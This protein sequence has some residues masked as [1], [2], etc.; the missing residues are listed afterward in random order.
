MNP[1][2]LSGLILN[3]R[4]DRLERLMFKLVNDRRGVEV[5]SAARARGQALTTRF[6]FSSA[7]IDGNDASEFVGIGSRD[8][9]DNREDEADEQE[10]GLDMEYIIDSVPSLGHCNSSDTVNAPS[11]EGAQ[12]ALSDQSYFRFRQSS[13]EGEADDT[14]PSFLKVYAKGMR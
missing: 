7:S 3:E 2:E 1:V 8:Q 5:A 6:P 12:E 10:E 9:G 4:I 14:S 13:S 11:L